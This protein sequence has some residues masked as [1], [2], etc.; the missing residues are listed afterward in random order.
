MQLTQ[1]GWY[2]RFSRRQPSA[3]R[4]VSHYRD[5]GCP[6]HVQS[7]IIGVR[8][9]CCV[10]DD[11]IYWVQ[12]RERLLTTVDRDYSLSGLSSCVHLICAFSKISA[13]VCLP[14]KD[15]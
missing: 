15:G 5:R 6:D 3:V 11:L 9:V 2:Q 7:T 8:L 10:Y 4:P 12:V 1:Q 13:F 14:R